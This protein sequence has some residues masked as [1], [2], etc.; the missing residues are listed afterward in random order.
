M[1]PVFEIPPGLVVDRQ[2][3]GSVEIMPGVYLSP[4]R[5]SL[6]IV[7]SKLVAPTKCKCTPATCG[8]KQ[9]KV[10]KTR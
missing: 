2:P 5:K 9:K 7:P 10:D 6:P 3:E 8:C 4:P 1:K